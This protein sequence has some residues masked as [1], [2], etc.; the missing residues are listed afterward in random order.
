MPDPDTAVHEDADACLAGPKT[1]IAILE[2]EI[3]KQL[4]AAKPGCFNFVEN[5]ATNQEAAGT[6][7]ND[8]KQSARGNLREFVAS[9]RD[10]TLDGNEIEWGE[11]LEDNRAD[12]FDIP[13][14]ELF[15]RLHRRD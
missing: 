3:R 10:K 6:D 15:K 4:P 14:Q 1:K 7:G 11:A 5:R 8:F 13:V 12:E 9:R 2:H